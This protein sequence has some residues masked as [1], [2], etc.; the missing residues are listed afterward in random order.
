MGDPKEKA[1]VIG[2]DTEKETTQFLVIRKDHPFSFR[3]LKAS[4][5][6]VHSENRKFEH[7]HTYIRTPL[8]VA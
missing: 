6:E 4:V 3:E 2:V 8:S 5:N 1:P 7:T